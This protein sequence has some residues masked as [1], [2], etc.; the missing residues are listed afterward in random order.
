MKKEFYKITYQDIDIA[1]D[2][3]DQNE[4]KF[5]E[6]ILATI[7]YYRNENHTF[8][9]KLVEKYF[10]SYKK[11]M[12]FVLQAKIKGKEGAE[13]RIENQSIINNTL[14]GYDKGTLSTLDAT[15]LPNNKL[16]ISNNK[17][18]NK[19][20]IDS[21]ML[22]SDYVKSEKKYPFISVKEEVLMKWFLSALCFKGE[23]FEKEM[24]LKTSYESL[25]LLLTRDK[26]TNDD[27]CLL[28]GFIAHASKLKIDNV[29]LKNIKSISY[30]TKEESNNDIKRWR[31][32]LES[33]KEQYAKNKEFKT[34]IDSMI[35]N[36]NKYE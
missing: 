8:K 26:L 17:D 25:K 31:S 4:K 30:L 21:K 24:K 15:L 29:H 3:F 28:I 16:E 23:Y 19:K 36:L 10:K 20:T 32:L 5:S 12:D 18:N 34:N 22:L 14:E 33:A 1:L 6:F 9:D 13:K 11:T 7:K 27:L 35:E 2:F